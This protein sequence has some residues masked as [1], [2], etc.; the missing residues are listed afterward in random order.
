[1]SEKVSGTKP[2]LLFILSGPSGVGKDAVMARLW[3][4]QFPLHFGVTATTRS[5]RPGEVPGV[6][7]Y[8]VSE[9]EFRRM[10]ADDE[11]LEWA[12]VHCCLY[13]VP[14]ASVRRYLEAG[15]DVLLRVDVQG[16]ATIRA[17]VPEAVLIF[18]AP[19]SMDSLIAR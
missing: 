19:P 12:E 17:K 9:T 15:E 11:M 1:M 13:G 5:P 4:E 10:V 2:G 8:F 7:Y 6:D 14:R 3:A 18:L 16:A